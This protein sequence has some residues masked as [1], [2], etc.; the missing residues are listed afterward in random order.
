M[1]T[2]RHDKLPSDEA[3]EADAEGDA[4]HQREEAAENP[5]DG[6]PDP[7]VVTDSGVE[8]IN[9]TVDG[10]MATSVLTRILALVEV[11]FSNSKTGTFWRS[12]RH[13]WLYLNKLS[14]IAVLKRLVAFYV[15]AHN[16]TPH[17]SFR[18]PAP[19]ELCQGKVH[20]VLVELSEARRR[21]RAERLAENR[22]RSCGVCAARAAPEG[23][24]VDG[25][26][27]E[28]RRAA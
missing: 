21:A 10:L 3:I 4:D 18:G 22:S 7:K 28:E 27:G 1:R 25:A 5:G 9:G 26:L 16:T 15:D 8:N 24:P 23:A 6:D 2:R 19:D 14:S 20:L 12:L 11:T 13:G 17:S